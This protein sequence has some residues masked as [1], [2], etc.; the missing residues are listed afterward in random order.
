MLKDSEALVDRYLAISRAIAGQ[1]DYQNV[2]RKVAEEVDS[3]FQPDHMDVAIILPDRR[4]CAVVFEVGIPTGWTQVTEP[5][6]IVNLP[7]RTLLWGQVKSLLTGDAWEDERFH[8][9]GSFSRP[10]FDAKLHSRLHVPMQVHGVV[11]GSLNIS[12][13]QK[14][15]Y[16]EADVETAQQVADLLA[17]YIYALIRTDQAKKAAMAEGAA[18]GREEALR[19]GALRLTE[20]MEKARKRLGMD[21]HDQTLADL[22]RISHRVARMG[23][24]KASRTLELVELGDEIATCIKELRRIIEDTKPGVLELF[25]FGQAVEAQLERSV[26][27]IKPP[28]NFEVCDQGSALLDT[29]PESQRTTLFR[30]VQEAINNAV[31]HGQPKSVSVLIKVDD[32]H[33]LI[34]VADNGRGVTQQPQRTVGGLDN[35]RVRAALISANIEIIGDRPKGGT[36]V[37]VRVPLAELQR[38]PDAV[39]DIPGQERTGMNEADSDALST[40]HYEWHVT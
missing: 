17:P 32:D 22:T 20:G 21:L 36:R 12:S 7:N 10:I 3:L 14:N 25:G 6:P 11:H 4:D 8:F 35:M 24:Q 29:C 9:D 26:A 39:D 33:L 16:T 13:H 38:P 27:G 18:R 30:I 23:R 34:E 40:V 15:K 28:I 1:L 37:A 5:S 19:L 2:L 31:K